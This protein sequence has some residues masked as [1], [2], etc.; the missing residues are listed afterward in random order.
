MIRIRIFL[1][2][3]K[4]ISRLFSKYIDYIDICCKIINR[5]END[6]QFS[7]FAKGIQRE[8]DM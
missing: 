7:N 1:Q 2:E 3:K 5:F 8:L 6:D 4:R